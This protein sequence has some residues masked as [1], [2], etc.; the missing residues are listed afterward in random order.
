MVQP[1]QKG[2][3]RSIFLV[4]VTAILGLSAPPEGVDLYATHCARCHEVY[5]TLQMR[6]LMKD[7]SPEYIV[8][9]LTTGVMRNMGAS[10][11]SEERAA[12]A[13]FL[14]GKKLSSGAVSAGVCNATEQGAL[15]GAQWN[16]WGVDPENTRFQ[17][18]AGLRPDQLPRLK[19]RWA[20]GFP[21][22]ASTYSQPTVVG[23]RLF[24][25]SP[26]GVVYALD[27]RTGCTYWS[28]DAG[29][30]VRAA[31]TI[32]PDN[33]AYFGDIH[34][35]VFAV[36]AFTGKQIWRTQAEENSSARI[37]GAPKLYDGRL[38]VP[39]ASRDE[40][41]ATDAGFGCCRFRGSV[42]AMEAKTGQRIWKTYTITEE[43]QRLPHES[44]DRGWGPSGVGVWS[45]PTIDRKLA[46]L[47]VGTG[48]NYTGPATAMS[49]SILALSLKTG[50]IV[51]SQQLTSGDIFL[52]ACA[53]KENR[54]CAG[55]SGPDADFG[56]SP[57]LCTARDGR[58]FLIAGQ[59]S[60]VL[61]AL[62][63]DNGGKVLWQTRLGKGGIFGGIQWGPAADNEVVYVAISD[64]A[65]KHAPEGIIPDP[66]TGGGLHAVQIATGR[67]LWRVMPSP[68]GCQD[69]RC[70]P[71]QSAAITVI[72]GAVFSGS[73][74]GHLRAYGT[75]DRTVI[76]DYDTVTSFQTVNGI[77]AKGGSIDGPGPVVVDGMLFVNSGYGS[78]FGMP[79]NVLLAF[80]L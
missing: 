66:K 16:G 15:T 28:F 14:T 54:K 21:G 68:D 25:G 24:V 46:L 8:R 76:W 23:N 74:D 62:N 71:A 63:P 32:G 42:V 18:N 53:E 48:D 65:Y 75:K 60:G 80:T 11:S 77:P 20:F 70:S 27:K 38:Y 35:N 50:R 55:K 10:L 47:Y 43:A 73:L 33:I 79:G 9:T 58:R 40:W 61:Y 30:G 56:S 49:D 69:V 51:W 41:S 45:S 57:M 3:V 59:K 7:M 67:E 6:R 34:A 2:A 4:C 37:T 5:P 52:G 12:L 1:L 19:L 26:L 72:P 29:A 31:I 13:D 39:I 44:S 22:G 64:V 17:K 78:L 36:D